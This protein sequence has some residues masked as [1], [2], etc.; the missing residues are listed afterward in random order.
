MFLQTLIIRVLNKYILIV[1]THPLIFTPACYGEIIISLQM[2]PFMVISGHSLGIQVH[3][4]TTFIRDHM[5]TIIIFLFVSATRHAPTPTPPPTPRLFWWCMKTG[6]VLSLLTTELSFSA[7][8]STTTT[9]I[10]WSFF[11]HR[12]VANPDTMR[13]LF[14]MCIIFYKRLCFKRNKIILE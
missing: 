5:A 10:I 7:H 4:C 11:R 12:P 9:N 1:I 3:L 2:L 8:H 6:P 13:F 14:F